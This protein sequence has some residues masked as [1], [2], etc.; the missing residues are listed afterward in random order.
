MR[1]VTSLTQLQRQSCNS[2]HS[3][4][5]VGPSSRGRRVAAAATI[6]SRSVGTTH[7]T[8]YSPTTTPKRP[9]PRAARAASAGADVAGTLREHHRQQ[10]RRHLALLAWAGGADVRV[11]RVFR[12]AG[13]VRRVHCANESRE[14]HSKVAHFI[15]D[16]PFLKAYASKFSSRG[17][18]PRTPGPSPGRADR[19]GHRTFCSTTGPP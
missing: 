17:L 8:P 9:T 10:Q 14:C 11:A 5:F 15:A 13:A 1:E 3:S 6:I 18:R 4:S 7:P 19:Q 16:R 2:H 12:A